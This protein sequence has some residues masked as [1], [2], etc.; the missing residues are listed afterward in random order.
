MLRRE[1]ESNFRGGHLADSEEERWK[2]VDQS[3]NCWRSRCE[4]FR[5]LPAIVINKSP[6]NVRAYKFDIQIDIQICENSFILICQ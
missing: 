5:Q 3:C 1:S 6:S 2:G 4:G